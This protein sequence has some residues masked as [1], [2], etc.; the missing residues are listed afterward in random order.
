[1]IDTFPNQG[2]DFFGALKARMADSEVRERM[3]AF[4]GR[5]EGYEGKPLPEGPP[6]YL[7]LLMKDLRDGENREGD[8][9]KIEVSL[10]KLLEEG[11]SLVME[12]EYVNQVRLANDYLDT[13]GF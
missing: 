9:I 2:L 10:E 7:R 3:E 1:M 13:A 5:V 12:Q 4:D 6:G 11:R 8:S